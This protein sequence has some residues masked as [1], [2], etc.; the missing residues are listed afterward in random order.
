MSEPALSDL[1][2]ALSLTHSTLGPG[3]ESTQI[4]ADARSFFVALRAVFPA[5]HEYASCEGYN[6]R[7]DLS[8]RLAGCVREWSDRVSSTLLLLGSWTSQLVLRKVRDKKSYG[9][10]RLST[11]LRYLEALSP[12]FQSLGC[13][14]DLLDADEAEI[15]QFY[16][17]LLQERELRNGAYVRRRLEA[18]RE[19]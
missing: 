17:D 10:L 7:R 8:R 12:G 13:E 2:P 5:P 6:A 19:S 16:S 18:V 1:G 3:G 14:I 15:T 9:Y 11:A 4:F